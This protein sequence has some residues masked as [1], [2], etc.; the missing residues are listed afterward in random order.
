MDDTVL[1]TVA[2]IVQRLCEKGVLH[3]TLDNA[4][5]TPRIYLSQQREICDSFYNTNGYLTEKKCAAF[6]I[7]RNRMEKFVKE[8]FVS[9]MYIYVCFALYILADCKTHRYL[10]TFVFAQLFIAQCSHA[11]TINYRSKQDL[12]PSSRFCSK[13]HSQPKFC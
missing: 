12:P 10:S 8:S 9:I 13:C 3:G 1:S 2:S 5:Y 7:S 11:N 6:G 4:T